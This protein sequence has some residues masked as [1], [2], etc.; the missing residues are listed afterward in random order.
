MFITSCI[1]RALE[2]QTWELS[3][4]FF[5]EIIEQNSKIKPVCLSPRALLLPVCANTKNVLQTASAVGIKATHSI[6]NWRIM[7]SSSDLK[8]VSYNSLRTLLL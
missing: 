4:C 2:L 8:W 6:Y 7:D 3:V 5:L 1:V